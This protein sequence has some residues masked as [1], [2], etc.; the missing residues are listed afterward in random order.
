MKFRCAVFLLIFAITLPV[1][2]TDEAKLIEN[3][4]QLRHWC[5]SKTK[6]FFEKKGIIA[7]NWAA[8]GW[9]R[10]NTLQVK[11]SWRIS[12]ESIAVLCRIK[13]GDKKE[14]ATFTI[15]NK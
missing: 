7:Y 1:N 9:I 8:T 15:I 10:N 3:S 11:G 12:N 13:K 4:G 5:K 2:A 6:A 14:N